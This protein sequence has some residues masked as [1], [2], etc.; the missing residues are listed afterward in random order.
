M[1]RTIDEIQQGIITTLSDNGIT[2]STSRTSR[3]RLWTFVVAVCM[4]T[5]EMLFD[6]HR[7]EVTGLIDLLKPHS[8]KWYANKAREF[9]NGYELVHDEDYYDNSQ[10]TEEQVAASKIVSY[11]AVVEQSKALRLKVARIV[12]GDLGPLTDNQKQSFTEYMARIKDAG[13]RLIIDSLP[14]DGLKLSLI[15]YYN[16]LVL[17]PDGNRIDGAVIDPVGKAVRNYLLS[18][19]FNGTL[20]LAYLIDALQ[21]V[22]GVVIPHLV[23]AQAQ[24][25]NFPYTSFDV[26]YNPDSGYLRFLVDTD[27]HIEYV[28]QS[29]IL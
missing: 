4:W 26:K 3:R 29:V 6:Q 11:S 17:N 19:P 16:P 2:I 28:P 12:D 9:Q 22:E 24:Y 27:L 25:G 7:V 14:P 18:L 5:L 15:V 13:V 8:L 21:Q 1:A 20:V 23:S 10:L